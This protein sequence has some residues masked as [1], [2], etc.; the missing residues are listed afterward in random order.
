M[1]EATGPAR[2]QD[3]TRAILKIEAGPRNS[4]GQGWAASGFLFE[5]K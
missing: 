2:H 1:L 4:Q 3:R 5:R